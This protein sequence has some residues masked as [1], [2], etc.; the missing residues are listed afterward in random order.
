MVVCICDKIINTI[1]ILYPNF[2]VRLLNIQ[3]ENVMNHCIYADR[4]I[5][6]DSK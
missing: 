2:N 3:V 4:K 1:V 5:R 6:K